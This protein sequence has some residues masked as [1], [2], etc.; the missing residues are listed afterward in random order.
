MLEKLEYTDNLHDLMANK[1]DVLEQLCELARQQSSVTGMGDADLLL[2]F[3][4]RKQPLMDRLAELQEGLS[5]YAHDDPEQRLWRTDQLRMICRTASD[6]CQLLLS[7]ILLLEKQSLDEMSMRRDALAAHLQDGRDGS[8]AS[9]A[10]HWADAL[11]EGSL[12]LTA[13]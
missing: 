8:S 4:A 11:N 2:S 9:Q 10:Y 3:L 12:D 1:V 6:R 13:G 7:E 5:I